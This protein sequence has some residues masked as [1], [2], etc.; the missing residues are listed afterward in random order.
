MSDL[1]ITAA[2][3][4]TLAD[5][6]GARLG[7]RFPRLD[8]ASQLSVLAV[9]SLHLNFDLW[10][11]KRIGICL[12]VRAGS[13][14]TD[15]DYWKGKHNPGGPSPTLFTYTLPSAPL[16]EIAIRYGLTG[17]NLCFVG[18]DS[19]ALAE[20]AEFLERG[21]ADACVCV[22]CNAVDGA[23]AELIGERAA[24]SACA[25]LL[26]RGTHGLRL[27]RENGSD[28]ESLYVKFRAQNSGLNAEHLKSE[29]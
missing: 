24:A 2:S 11:R 20:A 4:V 21:D 29:L 5:L 22:S 9:E 1:V 23:A 10:P 27:E 15:A 16:G 26:Q 6:G 17:P 12:A 25:L 28:M 8:L 19:L 7:T 13:L 14:S 3:H 18:A